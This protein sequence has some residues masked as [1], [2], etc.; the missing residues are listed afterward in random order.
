MPTQNEIYQR[1]QQNC[2][3]FNASIII[4]Y[5][6]IAELLNTM[7]LSPTDLFQHY[8]YIFE[9]PHFD[10]ER[11]VEKASTPPNKP[12]NNHQ[13]PISKIYT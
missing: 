7:V 2:G 11:D 6:N 9:A 4:K 1:A 5:N 8:S 13:Q 10:T 12:T 3:K